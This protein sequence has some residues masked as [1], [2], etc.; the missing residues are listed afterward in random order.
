MEI[1]GSKAPLFVGGEEVSFVSARVE[2]GEREP[3][4]GEPRP[5]S[6]A[7]LDNWLHEVAIAAA[8]RRLDAA[9]TRS[10]FTARLQPPA[11]RREEETFE[12]PRHAFYPGNRHA[13]RE[14]AALARRRR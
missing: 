8:H 1:D 7:A 12:L 6:E 11:P 14:Q 4:E 5:V 9:L 3:W 13:R 2:Q 10:V